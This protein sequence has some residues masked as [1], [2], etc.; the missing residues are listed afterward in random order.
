MIIAMGGWSSPREPHSIQRK[1]VIAIGLTRS[2]YLQT[3]SK[4]IMSARRIVW[5]E[6]MLA[7]LIAYRADNLPLDLCAEKV[8]V[9]YVATIMKARELKIAD[10][11]NS[12]RT[13]GW[14]IPFSPPK[15]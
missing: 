5:T 10:R 11:R 2:G 6:Q 8:G 9:G 7:A 15:T 14:R 12:G 1:V 4:T 13:P 3:D